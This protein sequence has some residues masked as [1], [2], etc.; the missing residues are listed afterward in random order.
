MSRIAS[1][2]V[3]IFIVVVVLAALIAGVNSGLVIPNNKSVDKGQISV[4]Q[5][6]TCTGQ[7]E[8]R[9]SATIDLDRKGSADQVYVKVIPDDGDTYQKELV[10]SGDS[11]SLTDLNPHDEI[12]VWI[13]SNDDEYPFTEVPVEGNSA[14]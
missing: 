1:K 10:E 7:Q 12:E 8:E 4:G 6:Y 2:R 11:V 9:C 13:L 14:N 3:G 5:E